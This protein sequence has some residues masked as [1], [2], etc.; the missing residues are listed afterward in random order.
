MVV[1]AAGVNLPGA[2]RVGQRIELVIEVAPNGE[3]SADFSLLSSLAFWRGFKLIR[4]LPNPR[5]NTEFWG[6]RAWSYA[7][8][9]EPITISATLEAIK[10]GAYELDLD[11]EQNFRVLEYGI[12]KA[13]RV[14]E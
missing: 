1:T 5:S 7:R 12:V 9:A 8:L 2:A 11:I 14:E 10:A 4:I 13:I 6:R 3:N